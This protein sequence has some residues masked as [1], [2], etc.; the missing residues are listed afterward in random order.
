MTNTVALIAALF[1][2]CGQGDSNF[3]LTSV[4]DALSADPTLLDLM[5]APA[6]KAGGA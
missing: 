3:P 5:G 2:R 6:N 1:S 4:V